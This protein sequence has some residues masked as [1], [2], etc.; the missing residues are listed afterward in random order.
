MVGFLGPNIHLTGDLV[1]LSETGALVRCKEEVDL[2][3]SGRLGIDVGNEI[4]RT[5][6][7]V[8][9]KVPGVGVAFEIS[10]MTPRNRDILHRLLFRM[11]W[12]A[13]W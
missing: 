13:A 1:N 3:I 10:H 4:L 2:N 6:A 8:R 7:V 11:G 12:H 9:R 5:V